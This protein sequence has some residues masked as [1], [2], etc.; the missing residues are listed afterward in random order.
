MSESH[1]PGPPEEADPTPDAGT[2][3]RTDEE[4][5]HGHDGAVPADQIEADRAHQEPQPHQG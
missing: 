1:V 3:E 4:V 5:A 2:Q